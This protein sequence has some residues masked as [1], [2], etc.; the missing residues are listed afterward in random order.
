MEVDYKDEGNLELAWGWWLADEDY[1]YWLTH[2]DEFDNQLE[3]FE[4]N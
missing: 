1:L 2:K 3:L 4:E